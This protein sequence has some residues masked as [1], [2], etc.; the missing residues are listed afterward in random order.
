LA[1]LNTEQEDRKKLALVC[2]GGTGGHLFPAQALAEELGRRG[3]AVHLATDKRGGGLKDRFPAQGVHVLPA[4]TILSRSPLA[5]IRTLSLL[6]SGFLKALSLIRHLKPDVVAGF[7]G[8]PTLPPLMAASA[9]R[10]PSI[11]HE[12]NAVMGRANRLLSRF[13]DLVAVSFDEVE[14]VPEGAKT[15]LRHTGIPVRGA[16]IA[17][18]EKPFAVPRAGGPFSLLVFGGSQGARAFADLVPP[19]VALLDAETRHRLKVCQQARPEDVERVRAAYRQADVSAEVEPFYG[20]LPA[21][22]A[23]AHLVIS[24]SGASTVAEVTVIGRPAIL[25]PLPGAIDNDQLMNARALERADAACL[26]PQSAL[27]PQ[28]LAGRIAKLMGD[29]ARLERIAA[30]ARAL[31]RKDAVAR[32][33]DLVEELGGAKN[34]N[35]ERAQ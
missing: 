19:A 7:G 28:V 10:A 13:A 17:A 18:A 33:A 23:A 11:L 3:Y 34:W 30:N 5:L 27:T 16:V 26:M 14:R 22:M 9:L 24:R 20:D 1:R 8:Y 29:A 15:R 2:A 6:F 25:V 31:G 4:A 35:T 12:Q 21:R 32:L